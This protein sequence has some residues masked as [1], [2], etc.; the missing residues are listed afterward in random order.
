MTLWE[1]F[2]RSEIRLLLIRLIL[3]KIISIPEDTNEFTK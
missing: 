2:S 1:F 3:T